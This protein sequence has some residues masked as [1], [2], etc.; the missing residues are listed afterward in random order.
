MCGAVIIIVNGGGIQ[1]LVI[2]IIDD[3]R[4]QPG[5]YGAFIY[6]L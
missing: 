2:I 5:G 6:I 3:L 4:M 1:G